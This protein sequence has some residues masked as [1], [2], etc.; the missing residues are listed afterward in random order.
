MQ[1]RKRDASDLLWYLG[2]LTGTLSITSD[3]VLTQAILSC[4]KKEFTYVT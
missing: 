1:G 2:E 3:T 4:K